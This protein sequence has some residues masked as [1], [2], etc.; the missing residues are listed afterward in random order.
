MNVR[1]PQHLESLS[2]AVTAV[3]FRAGRGVPVDLHTVGSRFASWP[4]H[5]Y[6]SFPTINTN[7]MAE[8]RICDGT[9]LAPL[10]VRW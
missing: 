1:F 5:S 2:T 8:A 9:A 3:T 10:T 7:N 6:V 4:Q